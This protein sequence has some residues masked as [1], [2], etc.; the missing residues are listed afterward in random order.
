MVS[1]SSQRKR[2]K[3]LGTKNMSRPSQLEGWISDDEDQ[4]K[5]LDSWKMRSL[6][7]HK[8]LKLSFFRNEGTR[9]DV[10]EMKEHLLFQN[11]NEEEENEYD[12][13]EEGST[14]AETS[15]MEEEESEDDDV[16]EE[17][18]SD[19]LLRTYLKKNKKKI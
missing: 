3:T 17:S 12:S 15:A 8:F 13:G 6:T 4:S 19:M 2:V 10:T 16:A 11:R 1:S 9:D 14:P 5:F 7:T 18:N